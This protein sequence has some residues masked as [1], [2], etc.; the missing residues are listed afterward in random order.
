[1]SAPATIELRYRAQGATL[2]R[3]IRDR[4]RRSFIIGPL[5]SGKTNASCYKTLRVMTDE[6]ADEHGVRRT[7]LA[8]IRNTYPD[9][10]TTTARDWLD[11]YEDL[12]HFTEGGLSPP[13][14]DIRFQLEDE[15]I[16]ES[17]LH[18]IALDRPAHIRKLRGLGLTA[19]WLNEV[20][21]LSKAT[22]DML[23]LRVGRFQPNGRTPAWYG[24]YGDSNAPDLD[25]WLYKLIENERPEG[26][27]FFKQPG[28]LIRVGADVH[29]VGGRWELNPEA[30]NVANLPG[31]GNYYLDGMQG[32]AEDWI[33]VNLAN[34]Y[35]FVLEGRPV[36]DEYSDPVHCRP[37]ELNPAIGLHIGLDFG[38]TPAAAIGQRLPGGGWRVRHEVVTFDMGAAN[39]AKVLGQFIREKLAA[40]SIETITGD[41][42]GEAR[43]QDEHESTVFQILAA[44]GI[45]A[46]PARTNEFSV[47]REAVSQQMLRMR[48][49]EQGYLL[50]PDC[51]VLRKAMQG[52]YCYRRLEVAGMDR[53][54]DVPD[55]NQWSHVAE[56]QQY[57][58]LGAG[59]GKAIVRPT[60]SRALPQLAI[61]EYVE[62]T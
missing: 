46:K 14:H 37:F 4:T 8:A 40:F 16:V 29:G 57:M 60:A 9:L 59:E 39:F 17:E 28:G 21:E 52:A 23:D 12:G 58:M 56:A 2:A 44:G 15:T 48:G 53:F 11:A 49:D 47:R 20:K 36:H 31:A 7:R 30:E 51:Q 19:A 34:Q 42:S 22:L 55:K 27:A 1:M 3:Y 54:K 62:L 32:K 6:A 18:F 38:L 24:L 26:Y 13:C 41:P 35:G 25:H 61:S 45:H 50:H 33:R 43:G 5:G 10:L